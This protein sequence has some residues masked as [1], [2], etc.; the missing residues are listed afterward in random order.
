MTKPIPNAEDAEGRL[1]TD[2]IRDAEAVASL[3]PK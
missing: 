3:K 2:N 1:S